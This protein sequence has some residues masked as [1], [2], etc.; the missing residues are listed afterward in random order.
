[1]TPSYN[2]G[3]YLEKTISSVLSQNYDNIEYFIIDGGSNDTSVDI[4]KKYE[5]KLSGWVSE[6]DNGQSHAINKGVKLCD[7]EIFGYINSDDFYEPGIIKKIVE[8]FEA[9]PDV[10]IIYGNFNYVDS[11]N[12]LLSEQFTIPFNS[13]VFIYDF[14]FICQPASFWRRNVF[15]KYG[16]FDENLQYLMDYE[17]FLRCYKK[18][19]RYK[20]INKTIANLRLH[21]DC[22]TISGQ[23]D[24]EVKYKLIRQEILNPYQNSI[25]GLVFGKYILLLLKILN[26][27]K[28]YFI[29]FSLHRRYKESYQNVLLK[30]NKNNENKT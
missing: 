20:Y 27:I 3:Q 14:D 23:R 2:Q 17:F 18:G 29:F 8:I 24:F 11:N 1:M 13:C 28:F 30:L 9:N 6:S 26:R 7:G 25:S 10:D 16:N 12:K 5:D 15:Q 4:I 21:S 22:K 19:V